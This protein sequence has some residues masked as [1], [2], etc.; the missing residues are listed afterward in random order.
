MGA[1]HGGSRVGFPTLLPEPDGHLS[2]HPVLRLSNASGFLNHFESSLM[3]ARISDDGFTVCD[4]MRNSSLSF[5]SFWHE[6]SCPPSPAVG[7]SLN[8]DYYGDCVTISILS[9]RI[10]VIPFIS[11]PRKLMVVGT[12]SF[13]GKRG[14]IPSRGLA[15]AFDSLW[16]LRCLSCDWF[17]SLIILLLNDQDHIIVF[18]VC[19]D[20]RP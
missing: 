14:N 3:R 6:F 2:M 16:H 18:K 20:A 11:T 19:G 17:G 7:L 8:S 5:F 13:G 1:L 4:C 15:M 9:D 12:F 10:T